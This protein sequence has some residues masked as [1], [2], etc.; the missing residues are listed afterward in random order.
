MNGSSASHAK[1]GLAI[2]ATEQQ[3]SMG[4]GVRS[5]HCVLERRGEPL[6]G[7]PRGPPQIARAQ[8]FS[9]SHAPA[10]AGSSGHVPRVLLWLGGERR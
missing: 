7:T 5:E 9:M 4:I 8:D 2:S 6:Q 10:R 1:R 3:L